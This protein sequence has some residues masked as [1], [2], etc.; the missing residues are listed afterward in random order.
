MNTQLAMVT[1]DD[2]KLTVSQEQ[3]AAL[4]NAAALARD[5]AKIVKDNGLSRR[6]GSAAKEHVFVE[7][8]LTISRVNNE[9]PHAEVKA[10]FK[11]PENGET[12][13]HA[14][15]WI[16]NAKGEIVSEAD[17]YC[18]T[19]EATWKGKPFYARASMAQTRAIG[20]AMRLRHAWVM[21]MAGFA[22]TPAEEMSDDFVE[23]KAT[24]KPPQKQDRPV[25]VTKV[26]KEA[27]PADADAVPHSVTDAQAPAAEP[28]VVP[29]QPN[30]GAQEVTVLGW[31]RDA[32]TG[33]GANG[34]WWK[35]GFKVRFADGTEDWL[36]VWSQ[37]KAEV[38]ERYKD[39]PIV[40]LYTKGD[41][42]GRKQYTLEEIYEQQ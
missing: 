10:T 16:T 1:E 26:Q 4:T 6:F 14:R 18:S 22:P 31:A 25:K 19:E 29:D 7:G 9:Q 20:K 3:R 8:W 17:G 11:D 35:K 13:I 39:K 38:L 37:P 40:V 5:V 33:Q 2:G 27:P 34:P 36:N 15:G 28:L 12:T 21:V 23:A 41:Y 30:A 32:K 24:V 42:N